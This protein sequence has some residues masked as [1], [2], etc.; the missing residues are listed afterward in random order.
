MTHRAAEQQSG[1]A[2]EACRGAP[3]ARRSRL[4]PALIARVEA[5]SHRVADVAAALDHDRRPRRIIDQVLASGTSVAANVFEADE[6]LSRADFCKTLGIAVKE[7]SETRY[8]IRFTGARG[9]IVPERL[10]GLE[11]ES[12]RLGRILGAMSARVRRKD[13]T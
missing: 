1:E 8:W 12:T 9:W 5:F 4:D 3:V 13:R 2:A 11:D 6:A 10:V 7:L